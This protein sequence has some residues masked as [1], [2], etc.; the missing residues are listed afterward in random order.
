[1]PIKRVRNTPVTLTLSYFMFEWIAS[2]CETGTIQK[3][4]EC[5]SVIRI[6][7]TNRNEALKHV[8]NSQREGSH[9][10]EPVSY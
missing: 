8:F 9:F 6:A 1:M 3:L 7:S 2:C 10:G 5:S 4:L